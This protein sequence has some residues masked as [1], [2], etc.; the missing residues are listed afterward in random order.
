VRPGATNWLR[1]TITAA[2]NVAAG[3]PGA[4]FTAVLVPGVRV[5]RYL[6]P[7][8]DTAGTSATSAVYSF[9]QSPAAAPTSGVAATAAPQASQV[10]A[11]TFQVRSAHVASVTAAAVPAPGPALNR[12]I[13]SLAPASRSAF[14]VTASSTWG[15][16]PRYGPDNLFTSAST[17]P[18]IAGSADTSPQLDVTWH[19]TRTI[20]ELVLGPASGAVAFPASVEVVSPQGTRLATVGQGGVVRLVPSLHTTQLSIVLMGTV[21]PGAVSGAASL[22]WPSAGGQHGREEVSDRGQRHRG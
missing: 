19:G 10:L 22:G 21:F 1:V 4:G 11:R 7:A 20:G 17:R 13:A 6:R 3:G 16:L 9:R 14:Q 8:Q 2:S 5:T 12:L 15:S 18:W